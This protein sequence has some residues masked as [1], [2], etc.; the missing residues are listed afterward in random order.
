M[1]TRRLMLLTGSSLLAIATST[2]AQ[3]T[4]S[5]GFQLEEVVVT[6]RRRAESL[7]DVPQT[8][9]AVSAATLEQ[10]NFTKFEDMQAIVPGL[11]MSA[12]ATGYTTAATIRG[13]SY[14]VESGATP[15]VE[16]Y[17]ND[18]P[19]QSNYL[20]QA[21]YDLGQVEV[22]RGP[23]GTL[24][25]RASPSGSITV[26][27]RQPDLVE[28]GGYVDVTGTDQDATNYNGGINLPIVTDKLALRI[29]GLYDENEF[30]QVE[31]INNSGDPSVRTKSGRAT[32]RFEPNDA[33]QATVMYQY[34]ERNLRSFDQAQSFGLAEPAAALV[35]PVIRAEDRLS[36]LEEARTSS[37]EQDMVTA[38]IDWR[39][40]GQKLSYVGSWAEQTIGA[41]APGDVGNVVPG[42]VFGQTLDTYQKQYSHELR[43]ASEER[44]FDRFDYTVGAFHYKQTSPS[45]LTN[46]TLIGT[47]VPFP[48]PPFNIPAVPPYTVIPIAVA[49][50]PISRDGTIDET[51]FFANLTWHITDNTEVSGGV[52]YLIWKTTNGLTVAGNNLSSLD[53]EEKPTIYNFAVSHRFTED[54]MIYGNYGRSWRDG[55]T[56]VGIF[57]PLTPNLE[58]FTELDPETSDSVEIGF[59]ADFLENRLRVNLS[60]FHQD[61]KDYLYRGPAVWYVNLDRSGAVPAQFNFVSNVDGTI[62]GAELSVAYQPIESLRLNASLAYAKG[63]IDNG[64]VACNDFDG[65]GV[66]DGRIDGPVTVARILGSIPSASPLTEAVN[67]CVINDRMATAPDWTGT[68]D[69]EYSHPI[70]ASLDGFVRGLYVYFPDNEQD[71]I[72]IYD[73]VNA[74]GTLNLYTGLRSSDGAWEVSLFAKNLTETEEY[75]GQ[76]GVNFG[77][78]ST[79][80]QQFNPAAPTSPTGASMTSS[81]MSARFTPER[82]IGLNVRYSFGSR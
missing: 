71:P 29:A 10:L 59:K 56:A 78:F 80:Y 17:L 12:G 33:I 4:A 19:I 36:V 13:A 38:Q 16:F 50:T 25:G 43:L 58:Q 51:S 49:D 66:P 7:Q 41:F 68:L 31:S 2:P 26:T 65:N 48:F 54:F 1:K 37:Q 70:G 30:D 21:M 57:R 24:R 9:D 14:Q 53:E 73:D 44:L 63:E 47:A 18:G 77:A 79:P 8:V 42:R 35:D 11:N 32:L 61:Y 81:Y 76:S 15:T 40:G 27:T 60:A 67:S 75:L 69:A 82:E 62:D 3:D 45:D 5:A 46:Q 20:F 34:L 6:A 28:F 74:Y 55:P 39:I 52:R 23:Q 64:T 22:L 72:N